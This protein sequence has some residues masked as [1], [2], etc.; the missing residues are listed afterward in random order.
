MLLVLLLVVPP[1]PPQEKHAQTMQEHT[2]TT[3]ACAYN[4]NVSAHDYLPACELPASTDT[5]SQSMRRGFGFQV[6][7]VSLPAAEAV[8]VAVAGAV[9][10][11]E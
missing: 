3:T 8:A 2:A 7:N 10:A 9:A 11:W 5:T 4:A 6:G 1:L